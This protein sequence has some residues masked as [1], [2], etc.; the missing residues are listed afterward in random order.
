MF[1]Y[2]VMQTTWNF[3]SKA[4][5]LQVSNKVKAIKL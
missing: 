4:V 3:N 2:A 5:H 1:Y